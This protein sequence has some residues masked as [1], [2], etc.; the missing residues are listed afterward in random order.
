MRLF[1]ADTG[2]WIALFNPRDYLHKTSCIN[3]RYIVCCWAL[4]L[5]HEA[6]WR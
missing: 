3:P 2:Y 4:A 1:F 5:F 6:L